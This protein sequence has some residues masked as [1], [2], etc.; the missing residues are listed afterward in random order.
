MGEPIKVYYNSD[1]HEI[2]WENFYRILIGNFVYLVS[3]TGTDM[4]CDGIPKMFET[5]F[6]EIAFDDTLE[7]LA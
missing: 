1:H 4:S 3:K 5:M 6:N 2:P 7:F